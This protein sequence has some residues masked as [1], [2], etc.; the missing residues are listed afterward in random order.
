MEVIPMT[1]SMKDAVVNRH[2][3]LRNKLAAGKTPKY[4][5]AS[6]MK[7]IVS[8][9]FFLITKLLRRDLKLINDMIIKKLIKYENK[10]KP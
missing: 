2:N 9:N 8:N 1:E 7:E 5:S 4:P 3:Q 6:R 10:K